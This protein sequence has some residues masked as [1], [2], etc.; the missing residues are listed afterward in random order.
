MSLAAYRNLLRAARIA[1]QG[2][3][4]VLTEAKNRIRHEF[5]TAPKISPTDPE[6]QKR[7]HYAK[8]IATL[9]RSNVVQGVPEGDNLYKLRIHEEIERGDNDSIK[10]PKKFNAGT[11]CC[12]S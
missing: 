7:M 10:N 3:D 1:F 6:F 4:R 9:L 2:D 5:R 8:D 12:S 11:G